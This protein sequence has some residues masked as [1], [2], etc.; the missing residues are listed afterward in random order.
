[1]KKASIKPLFLFANTPNNVVDTGGATL[2]A[3]VFA[4][5]RKNAKM[6][7]QHIQGIGGR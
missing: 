2:V 6:R 3:N 7:Y 1:M 4:D 5:F